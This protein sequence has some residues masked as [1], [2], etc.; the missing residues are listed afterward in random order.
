MVKDERPVVKLDSLRVSFDDQR[1]VANAGLTLP[2]SLASP[3]S[4][5]RWPPTTPA[6]RR[7]RLAA[8][9]RA[10]ARPRATSRI[11]GLMG[12]A[13]EAVGGALEVRLVG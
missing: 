12:G 11:L 2:A 10:T 5:S 9:S 4:R 7:W 1:A 8:A 3:R 6:P 13:G